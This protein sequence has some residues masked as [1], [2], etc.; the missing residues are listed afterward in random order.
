[1]G[2][3]Y[4]TNFIYFAMM[5]DCMLGITGASITIYV[6]YDCRNIRTKRIHHILD[7]IGYIAFSIFIIGLIYTMIYC[8]KLRFFY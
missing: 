3:Q 6:F 8:T 2:E 4:I 5:F 1:M 7:F